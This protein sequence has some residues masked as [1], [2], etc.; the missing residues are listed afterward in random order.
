MVSLLTTLTL[1][2][3]RPPF[4]P[5]YFSN[6]TVSARGLG[7]SVGKEREVTKG[8]LL[9]APSRAPEE[10]ESSTVKNVLV[11]PLP[12]GFAGQLVSRRRASSFHAPIG[13]ARARCCLMEMEMTTT[14][15]FAV[16]LSRAAVC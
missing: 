2:P 16:A 7:F 15:A 10:I 11:P 8:A 1:S 14:A 12:P 5:A 6:C 3:A 13:G 9:G 4:N